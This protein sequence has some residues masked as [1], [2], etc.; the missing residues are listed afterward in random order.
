MM[1]PICLMKVRLTETSSNKYF[2]SKK[3]QV[4]HCS[5]FSHTLITDDFFIFFKDIF[6][7][8]QNEGNC[9]CCTLNDNRYEHIFLL[10][11]LSGI[12]VSKEHKSTWITFLT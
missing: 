1:L 2:S 9:I 5:V 12:R 10:G 8:V 7:S 11:A 3:D 6:S 4:L